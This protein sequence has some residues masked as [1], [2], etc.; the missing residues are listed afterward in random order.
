[1]HILTWP[2]ATPDLKLYTDIYYKKGLRIYVY[3]S[4]HTWKNGRLSLAEIRISKHMYILIKHLFLGWNCHTSTGTFDLDLKYRQD[5][6]VPVCCCIISVLQM[7]QTVPVASIEVHH[8]KCKCCT[9][10]GY[11]NVDW[12]TL[13]DLVAWG[14]VLLLLRPYH[15]NQ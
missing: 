7:N 12:V 5:T 15:T 1:M 11:I 3:T 13:P 2:T 10:T 8:T 9:R 14:L 4:I 6:F